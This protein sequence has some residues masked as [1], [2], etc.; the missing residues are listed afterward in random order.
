MI[1]HFNHKRESP[2]YCF[3]SRYSCN[4]M[5][6]LPRQ[7]Q[8]FLIFGRKRSSSVVLYIKCILQKKVIAFFF[9]RLC[10][11]WC[12]PKFQTMHASSI[13]KFRKQFLIDFLTELKIRFG[14]YC[15]ESMVLKLVQ[16]Y[17]SFLLGQ[18]KLLTREQSR[19]LITMAQNEPIRS[20]FS[21]N[22]FWIWATYLK[23]QLGP[24]V[25]RDEFLITFQP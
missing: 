3:S 23:I 4:K 15:D 21:R 6:G 7:S 8:T 22:S 18:E 5:N 2:Y 12:C 10:N 19:T 14:S 9:Q 11:F 13:K 25:Q 17:W 1:S 24:W 16:G 20:H